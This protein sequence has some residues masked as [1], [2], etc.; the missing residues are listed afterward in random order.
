M[1]W[2]VENDAFDQLDKAWLGT[3][4]R[5]QHR[6][7]VRLRGGS[8]WKFALGLVG[9]S[10]VL[11]RPATERT[12]GG[13]TYY[14]QQIPLHR[15][16]FIVMVDFASWEAATFHWRPP[17]WAA[18]HHAQAGLPNRILPVRDDPPA[19]LLQVAA[20]HAFWDL[21]V[22]ALHGIAARLGAEEAIWT[23]DLFRCVV[24]LVFLRVPE[25]DG[26]GSVCHR[27]QA[28]GGHPQEARVRHRWRGAQIRGSSRGW[29]Q[30]Q[31]LL[32]AP[33]EVDDPEGQHDRACGGEDILTSG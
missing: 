2:A 16:A 12:A 8:Q 31:Q 32:W 4:A 13:V 21:S 19:P 14:E 3:V 23:K 28:G 33:E 11:A 7:L 9:D 24:A 20:A 6:L 18:V 27:G 1:N 29:R 30:Q 25:E 15:P 22:P 26:G 10:V 17:A 5:W